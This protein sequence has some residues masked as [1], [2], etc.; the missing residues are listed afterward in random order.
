MISSMHYNNIINNT[1]A[2][3]NFTARKPNINTLRIDYF[4]SL[5]EIQKYKFYFNE[6]YEEVLLVNNIKDPYIKSS[7]IHFTNLS[8][9]NHENYFSQ[10]ECNTIKKYIESSMK[11]IDKYYPELTKSIHR[12]IGCCLLMKQNGITTGSSAVLLGAI[13]LNPSVT[14]KEVNYCDAIL[15]ES[16][17]QSIY[18]D[19]MVN[20]IYAKS[21]N[22]MASVEGLVTSS[23]RKV[24]RSMIV[25]FRQLAHQQY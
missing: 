18:L 11:I 13:L 17:H 22:D 2:V 6:D 14:W 3:V 7:F 24:K 20:G 25:L 9:L 5:N 10:A 19:D 16:M 1:S 21:L 15:H 23:I 8:E 4:N 12:L